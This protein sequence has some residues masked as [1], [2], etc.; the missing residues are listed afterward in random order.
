[1]IRILLN[2][3]FILNINRLSW[4][5]NWKPQQRPD[6]YMAISGIREF[7]Q[8]ISVTLRVV[9][10]Y[11]STW[12]FTVVDLLNGEGTGTEIAKKI[13]PT[14]K[15]LIAQ[16]VQVLFLYLTHLLWVSFRIKLN[17]TNKMKQILPTIG[18]TLLEDLDSAAH[19]LIR[20]V[21]NNLT[22]SHRRIYVVNILFVKIRRL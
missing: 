22:E 19:D 15:V 11:R 8:K 10:L 5:L 17:W 9:F 20:T 4:G 7:V 16:F 21:K 12:L 6:K 13:V 1:M 18:R 2:I 3:F 14:T